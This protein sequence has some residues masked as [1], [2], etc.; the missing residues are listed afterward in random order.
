MF[1]FEHLSDKARK[2]SLVVCF[3]IL[4]VLGY[5]VYDTICDIQY[6][7]DHPEKEMVQVKKRY[8]WEI[9]HIDTLP[10][11]DK[12]TFIGRAVVKQQPTITTMEDD[13]EIDQ[14]KNWEALEK[15]KNNYFKNK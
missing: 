12:N 10:G 2:T 8:H 9:D 1:N 5:G 15:A 11:S 3:L 13:K 7:K 6:K 4:A 14:E